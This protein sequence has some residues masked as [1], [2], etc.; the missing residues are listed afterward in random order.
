[1]KIVKYAAALLVCLPVL[2]QADSHFGSDLAGDRW[3][4]SVTATFTD[5]SLSGGFNSSVKATTIQP[6]IGLRV[7]DD[8]EFW[9]SRYGV[10]EPDLSIRITQ[11]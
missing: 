10:G 8:A 4:A 11:C 2:G 7:G 6:R 5:T 3:F 1:M 9:R